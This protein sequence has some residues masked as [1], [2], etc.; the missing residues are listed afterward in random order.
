MT[1]GNQNNAKLLGRTRTGL[2]SPIPASPSQPHR[3]TPSRLPS[4]IKLATPPDSGKKVCEAYL[5]HSSLYPV[6][7]LVGPAPQY[8]VDGEAIAGRGGQHGGVKSQVAEL[9]AR[10]RPVLQERSAGQQQDHE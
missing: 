7:L 4:S 5:A 9:Q 3:L 10:D 8:A 1:V 2:E 6:D